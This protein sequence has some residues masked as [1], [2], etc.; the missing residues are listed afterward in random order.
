MTKNPFGVLSPENLDASYIAE[1]FV[2]L[3]T[4]LHVYV[5]RV[6]HSFLEL[7]A[8]AKACSCVALNPR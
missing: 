8:L 6:T 5:I 7:A 1:N 3:S 4:D 2:E